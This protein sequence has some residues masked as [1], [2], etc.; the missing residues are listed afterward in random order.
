MFN[1]LDSPKY[2]QC[3]SYVPKYSWRSKSSIS[4]SPGCPTLSYMTYG[5]RWP[6]SRNGI[7]TSIANGCCRKKRWQPWKI[8]VQHWKK[9]G[10]AIQEAPWKKRTGAARHKLWTYMD[11]WF[12]DVGLCWSFWIEACHGMFW[13]ERECSHVQQDFLGAWI[14][15]CASDPWG[16]T[17]SKASDQ[18]KTYGDRCA[19]SHLTLWSNIVLQMTIESC[20]FV[21][22]FLLFHERCDVDNQDV[23]YVELLGLSRFLDGAFSSAFARSID[24]HGAEAVCWTWIL[25]LGWEVHPVETATLHWW[26]QKPSGTP[27]TRHFQRSK[28]APVHVCDVGPKRWI[29]A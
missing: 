29:V 12:L 11:V 1:F 25:C 9:R 20:W 19:Q 7:W 22:F 14:S 15:N 26:C 24:S 4:P 21:F 16:K 17:S 6:M 27:Q 10:H 2:S 5:P 28:L 18:Q 23:Q 8:S 3:L 13:F